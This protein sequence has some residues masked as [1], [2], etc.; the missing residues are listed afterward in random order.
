MPWLEN[1]VHVDISS[2]FQINGMTSTI[3]KRCDNS[4]DCN[5]RPIGGNFSNLQAQDETYQIK[6]RDSG[7]WNDSETPLPHF[8][9]W[10]FHVKIVQNVQ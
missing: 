10:S 4:I 3:S 5:T 2:Q 8:Q 9:E 7:M 1:C 6:G